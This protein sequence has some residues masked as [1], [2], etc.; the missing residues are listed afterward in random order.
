MLKLNQKGALD[1]I[2]IILLVVVLAMGGY[3]GWTVLKSDKEETT[4]TTQS[5]KETTEAK[6]E[7][8]VI[9]DDN[10]PEGWVEYQNDEFGLSL[11]HPADWVVGDETYSHP[12]LKGSVVD[13]NSADY[14]GVEEQ[15]GGITTEAGAN[16]KIRIY[17]TDAKTLQE[18][19]PEG[20]EGLTTMLLN[21]DGSHTNAAID[22][23]DAWQYEIDYEGDSPYITEL[24]KN[25]YTYSI[26][27]NGVGYEDEDAEFFD[28]YQQILETVKVD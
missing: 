12:T 1:P 11:Y 5:N 9:E 14:K 10:I 18:R 19:Y 2:V 23:N 8:Q 7:E 16:V 15:I 3:I 27:F 25:G 13:I 28:V 4:E 24:I 20:G 26:S 22:G 21:E 17:E 6:Q